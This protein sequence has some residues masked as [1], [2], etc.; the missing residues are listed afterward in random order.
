MKTTAYPSTLL[1]RSIVYVS[2]AVFALATLLPSRAALTNPKA[3]AASERVL[4]YLLTQRNVGRVLSAQQNKGVWGTRTGEDYRHVATITSPAV[5]PAIFGFD[6]G[7]NSQLLIDNGIS[8]ATVRA[9]LV[10]EATAWW[11]QGAL[12]TISWHQTNP[13][14][15]SPDVGGHPSS[16]S[17]MSGT[18]FHDVVTPGTTLHTKWRNHVDL[19]APYLKDLQDAGVPVL[20]RPY[21][22][23]NGAWFWW[24]DHAGHN[25]ADYVQLWRNLHDRLVTHHGL[26]NLIWVWSPSATDTTISAFYPGDDYVDISGVDIYNSVNTASVY[27]TYPSTLTQVASGKPYALTEVGRFPA[28]SPMNSTDYL[29]VL[30]WHSTFLDRTWATTGYPAKPSSSESNTPSTTAAFYNHPFLVTL[31]EVVRAK[32]YEAELLTARVGGAT[33]I[34]P[35]TTTGATNDAITVLQGDG[36][37]DW[38]EFDTYV[39]R[40]GTYGISARIARKNDAGRAQLSVAGTPVGAEVDFYAASSS[41]VFG[42]VDLGR[43]TFETAGVKTFR[44]TTT[45]KHASSSS[46]RLGHD[47]ITLA[48]HP[49]AFL[50]DFEDGNANGWTTTNGSWSIVTESGMQRYAQTSTSTASVASSYPEMAVV[51][52]FTLSADLKMTAKSGTA[53]SGVSLVFRRQADGLSF[54]TVQIRPEEGE[55]RVMKVIN[56][57]SSAVSTVSFASALNQLYRV[58]LIAAGDQFS[59]SVNGVQVLECS[60]ADLAAGTIGLRFSGIAATF[61]QFSVA[62]FFPLIADDFSDG[63]AQGWTPNGGT[64]SVITDGTPRYAQTSTAAALSSAYPAMDA[65]TDISASIKVKVTGHSSA[66]S[67][68]GVSLAFRR[69]DDNNFYTL[70]LRYNEQDIRLIRVTGGVSTVLGAAVPFSWSLNTDYTLKVIALGDAFTGYV[71]GTQTIQRSDAAHKQGT[72]GV[73]AYGLAINLDDAIIEAL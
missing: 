33:L 48:A 26:N 14:D 57:V 29:W 51:D 12:V 62:K 15:A 21:H 35:S 46:Y 38:I 42:F 71:N 41:P 47:S 64:W 22:E 27:S 70:Q 23:M 60:D 4:D 19:I 58:T 68:E 53:G 45:G 54:Y 65:A 31:D 72:V 34:S 25:A 10:D 37:G 13:K 11:E 18:E 20:W 8:I 3:F 61:G 59:V 63:N 43:F 17:G 2:L 16:Q 24:G 73:R 36:V 69:I 40:G 28:A 50:D 1:R 30:C 32:S 66:T 39:P 56:N 55:L 52:N 5:Y 44:F 7:N 49:S 9:D 67:S 6:I